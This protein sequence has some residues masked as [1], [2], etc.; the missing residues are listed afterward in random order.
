[1]DDM[2][3]TD[4][5]QKE[6]RLLKNDAKEEGFGY[7]ANSF[8]GC[9]ANVALIYNRKELIVAN[10]GDSRSVLS[11]KGNLFGMSIDHKPDMEVEKKRIL[12]AG[13]FVTDGRVNANLN[14]SRALGD[15]EYKQNT[16]KKPEEQLIIALP[17][18]KRKELTKDDEFLLMGCDG[19]WEMLPGQEILDFINSKLKEKTP[20][21]QI[22]DNLLEKIIAP[23]TMRL[24]FI[25]FF[26][27][28]EGGG[29]WI[30]INM[31]KIIAPQSK[32]C[33]YIYLLFFVLGWLLFYIM[34]IYL[35]FDLYSC[36]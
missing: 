12:E 2:L 13:G 27:S 21:K 35:D 28:C 32:I 30:L 33:L 34:K 7:Q 10:A 1:M 6:L 3:K 5:G 14:L 23:D 8:A 22:M 9:T 16:K 18:C 36:F 25:S 19:I 4:E 11:S 29:G 26:L 31:N 20:L 15:L 24:N 17:D